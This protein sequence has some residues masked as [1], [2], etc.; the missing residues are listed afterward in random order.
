MGWFPPGFWTSFY[1]L[2]WSSIFT[3]ANTFLLTGI[4]GVGGYYAWRHSRNAVR[5]LL[6]FS[7]N[8]PVDGGGENPT[9][10]LEL[11]NKGLGPAI[12]TSFEL[13]VRDE[14]MVTSDNLPDW[15]NIVAKIDIP[16]EIFGDCAHPGTGRRAFAVNETLTIVS[17]MGQWDESNEQQPLTI[18]LQ[19]F[20]VNQLMKHVRIDVCFESIHGETME[21]AHFFT[22]KSLEQ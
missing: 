16:P 17:M 15:N 4:A 3:A 1:D 21:S 14:L 18:A 12:V 19:A 7:L 5:P 10:S 8:A 11:V 20:C 9:V 13:Y 2:P 22:P 6:E